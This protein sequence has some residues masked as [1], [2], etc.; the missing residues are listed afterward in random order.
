MYY[1]AVDGLSVLE[2]PTGRLRRR[3]E[4]E[5]VLRTVGS[6]RYYTAMDGTVYCVVDGSFV[7]A[8]RSDP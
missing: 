5:D 3:F 7:R 1:G 2:L 8:I 4:F 6:A